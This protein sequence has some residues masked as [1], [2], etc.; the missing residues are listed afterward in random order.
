VG[1]LHNVLGLRMLVLQLRTF[2][3]TYW[4]PWLQS[5]NRRLVISSSHR[6]IVSSSHR[7]RQGLWRKFRSVIESLT[8]SLRNRIPSQH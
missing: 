1:P 8:L 7:Q 3:G 4:R 5:L 2:H 6:L